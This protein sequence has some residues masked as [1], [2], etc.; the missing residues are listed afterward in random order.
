MNVLGFCILRSLWTCLY[1]GLFLNRLVFLLVDLLLILLILCI[2]WVII[3]LSACVQL[4][5]VA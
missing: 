4:W 1:L 2:F 5:Q 3:A